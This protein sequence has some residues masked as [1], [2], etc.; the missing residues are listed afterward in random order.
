M[1]I[2][3]DMSKAYDGVEWIFFLKSHAETRVQPGVD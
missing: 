3:L 1:T 2:R